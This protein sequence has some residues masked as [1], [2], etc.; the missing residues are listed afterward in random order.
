MMVRYALPLVA[1]CVAL[2]TVY[3]SLTQVPSDQRA[4]IR[5]FGKLLDQKPQPGLHIGWPWGI[6]QVDLVPVGKVRIITVGFSD[7]QER[8]DETVPVGQLLT[9]DHNLVNVQATIRFNV[10]EQDMEQYVLQ[11]ENVDAFVARAGETLLAEWIAGR[12]VNDVLKRG[13]SELPRFVL[14]H[15][16]ER[17]AAYGL[18]IE[19]EQVSI[20]GPHPPDE[21]KSDF[22]R[23]A[24]AETGKVTQ[25]NQADEK[26]NSLRKI[27]EAE[28][29]RIERQTRTYAEVEI[30]NAAS[31]AENFRK[32]LKQYQTLSR[33]NPQYLNTLW[34][35]ETTRLFTRMKSRGQIELLDHFLTDGGLTITQFPL[36]PRKK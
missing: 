4:V 34:L 12:N 7:K 2:W 3:T 17:I 35:D 19:I 36:Q 20:T 23:V 16:P 33:D 11:K 24:Q 18:G 26:A 13:K 6:D 10:R 30:G 8:D 31:E 28:A 14:A 29:E 21:V 32:R 27:A 15:F 5:R 25:I 9:G 22:D 1:A